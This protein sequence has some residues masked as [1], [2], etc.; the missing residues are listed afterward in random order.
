MI[1]IYMISVPERIN[2]KWFTSL[3]GNEFRNEET[4]EISSE[5][6]SL[7]FHVRIWNMKLD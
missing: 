3:D 2:Q 1:Q 6:Y 4:M 7:K 5:R